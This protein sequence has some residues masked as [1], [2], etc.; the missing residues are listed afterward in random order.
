MTIEGAVSPQDCQGRF[1]HG[2]PWFDNGSAT[3]FFLNYYCY[4]YYL[5]DA[6]N[7]QCESQKR[8]P[9]FNF[10][11]LKNEKTEHKTNKRE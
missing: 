3:I 5:A 6:S 1:D 7:I 2:A 4:Y 11:S 10:K 9:R 8:K